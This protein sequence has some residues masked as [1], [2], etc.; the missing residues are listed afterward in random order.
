MERCAGLGLVSL[1]LILHP[2]V[3]CCLMEKG[4]HW[5]FLGSCDSQLQLGLGNLMGN[6]NGRFMKGEARA[7]SFFCV[8]WCC[9]QKLFVLWLQ[10]LPDK[11]LIILAST[12]WP[13]PWALVAVLFYFGGLVRNDLC[14]YQEGSV[15]EQYWVTGTQ[16]EKVHSEMLS[17]TLQKGKKIHMSSMWWL[18]NFFF[19]A[20][21]CNFRLCIILLSA[22]ACMHQWGWCLV[23]LLNTLEGAL[24]TNLQ[25]L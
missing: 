7:F 1:R 25:Q 16:D 14:F 19:S 11:P 5:L 15:T 24:D 22:F 3:F 23:D 21:R 8:W 2:S 20:Q 17:E 10:F 18:R 12:V 6:T 9:W 4:Q 13:W